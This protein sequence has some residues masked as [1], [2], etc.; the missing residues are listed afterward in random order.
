MAG[1]TIDHMTL[2]VPGLSE[3]QA[4]EVAHRVAEGLAEATGLLDGSSRDI[5]V[6][7]LDLPAPGGATPAGAAH[8]GAPTD[9]AALSRH[10]VAATLRAITRSGAGVP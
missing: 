9:V 6:L 7:R 5:P 10:I 4:R 8:P 3:Q 1:L 2:E